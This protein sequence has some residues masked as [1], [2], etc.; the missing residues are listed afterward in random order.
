MR[1]RFAIPLAA[2]AA[3]FTACAADTH[4]Q[5]EHILSGQE[6]AAALSGVVWEVTE[7]DPIQIIIDRLEYF[8]ADGSWSKPQHRRIAYDRYVISGNQFCTETEHG[9]GECRQLRTSPNGLTAWS[10]QHTRTV[11][12]GEVKLT[13]RDDLASCQ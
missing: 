5:Q 9:A 13:A 10:V 1:L 12:I 3:A 11:L 8:C 2:I 7:D 6:L 4:I